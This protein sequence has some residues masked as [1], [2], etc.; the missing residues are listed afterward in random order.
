MACEDSS[1]PILE[2]CTF[3]END[4]SRGGGVSCDMSSTPTLT[5]CIF[6]GN[7]ASLIGGGVYGGYNSY[8]TLTNCTFVGNSAEKGGGINCPSSSTLTDCTFSG[9]S[10]EMGGGV[11]SS[12]ASSSA[13][14][15]NCT[16]EGNQAVLG[17]GMYLNS[18]SPM[19]TG[20]IIAY[21]GPGE[22]VSYE[23]TSVPTLTC[24]DIYGNA[25]GNWLGILWPQLGMDGNISEDPLFCDAS[26]GDYHLQSDSPC[27]PAN[28]ECGLMGA[29]S[30]GCTSTESTTWSEVKAM[31]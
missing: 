11:Y 15:T 14:L 26:L 8:A 17:G 9:N 21:N 19:L 10:A 31:Y 30:V 27:A 6:T 5:N 29:W 7:N 22:A 3:S 13:T 16:F 12:S 18:S 28:N 4:A 23:G 2:E 25:G 20:C 1:S 24:C